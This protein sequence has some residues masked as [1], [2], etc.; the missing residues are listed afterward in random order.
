M[1]N[2]CRWLALAALSVF[3]S[4]QAEPHDDV[5]IS[6][7]EGT[8][9][10]VDV[11]PDGSELAFD[12]LGDIYVMPATGGTARLLR[13]GPAIEKQPRFS[14]DGQKLVFISDADGCD[15]VWTMRRDGSEATQLT[16]ETRDLMTEPTWHPDG[17]RIVARKN[18]STQ[19][20]YML[21]E[22][23]MFDPRGGSGVR[24]VKE[25]KDA[26]E[27]RFS[28]DGRFLYY[29]QDVTG[30][31]VVFRNP[32]ENGIV[33]RRLTL[34]GGE[35]TDVVRGYGGALAPQIARDGR[36]LAFVRR[37]RERSVLFVADLDTGT[38]RPVYGDLSQDNQLNPT[39]HGWYPAFAWFPDNRHVAVWSHGKILRVDTVAG[40]AQPI[41]FR[42]E[43]VH[44][45]ERRLQF[46]PAVTDDR[47]TV[48]VIR[49]PARSSS[50]TLVFGA[51]GR[52]WRSEGAAAPRRLTQSTDLEVE[53]AFSADGRSLLFVAWNDVTGSSLRV[54][55]LK[56]GHTRELFHSRALVRAPAFSADGRQVVFQLASAETYVGGQGTRAGIYRL[57]LDEGKETFV[58]ARGSRPS[59]SPDGTRIYFSRPEQSG[60]ALFSVR[61]DGLDERMHVRTEAA[62]RLALSPDGR[63]IAVEELGVVYLAPYSASGAASFVALG[64]GE[65]PTRRLATG[66]G[67]ELHWS[68]DSSAV[69]WV[70]GAEYFS[71]PVTEVFPVRETTAGSWQPRD[72]G[73][74][75]G[76][77]TA[78]DKPT[79]KVAF[80][81]ARLVTMKGD[82]VIEDG[83]VVVS[84][85]R[86]EAVGVRGAV[87]VPSDAYVVDAAGT[88]IIPGMFDMHAHIHH[89][90]GELAPQQYPPYYAMLAF[91]VTTIMDP[92]AETAATL[93]RAEQVRAG[94][95]VGPRVYSTGS[96]ILGLSGG[97]PYAAIESLDDARRHVAQRASMGAVIVKS[98]MQPRRNQRQWLIAAAREQGMMVAPE[99]GLNFY[100]VLSM[101]LDGH[102]TIEHGLPVDEVYEDVIQLALHSGASQTPTLLVAAGKMWGEDYW[103]DKERIWD[104]ARIKRYVP[105]ALDMFHGGYKPTYLRAMWTPRATDEVYESEFLAVARAHRKLADRGVTVNV[106]AHGQIFGIGTHWELWSLQKG[107]MSAHQALRAATLNG[108]RTLGLEAQLG[109]LEPG[110]LADLVVLEA[111][112]LQD[113][114]ATAGV[115]FTMANGR[116]YDA[117]EMN[118]TG[119]RKRARMPFLWERTASPDIAWDQS[120]MGRDK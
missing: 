54:M 16:R 100:N 12:L 52:L 114:R 61:A 67:R 94:V 34:D 24:L 45:I 106:G 104:D 30:P 23:W 62:D 56:S 64:R 89:T 3:G 7:D 58:V 83:V 85:N 95:A 117:V 43:A 101:M 39:G 47:F 79:G 88:T 120:M 8:W 97:A 59:F 69:H 35:K 41:P 90:F 112:P 49:H 38:Q 26:T 21:G 17:R 72:H 96:P 119:N 28:P 76:L 103:Y 44:R 109:S 87:A 36:Q 84:G 4:V 32:G 65:V 92:S 37:V 113:I 53:P 70:S 75:L 66:L 6:V 98:Y 80:V 22:L 10:S 46:S 105:D 5:T 57:G 29:S 27:P 82:E 68:P 99:A 77:E 78:A 25:T 13:G 11:S 63:W 50:G 14:P 71:A 102:T 107:G 31:T 40:T 20:A 108:A 91:G 15:N 42:A 93:A 33:V 110:K 51:L 86:I 111:N 9:M 81:G 48:R 55:N 74:M 2:C 73:R 115:R 19:T 1:S 116:L 118:E 18:V 60:V